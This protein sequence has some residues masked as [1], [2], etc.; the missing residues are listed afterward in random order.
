MCKCDLCKVVYSKDDSI[1]FENKIHNIQ[2]NF[3][4]G[5]ILD[6]EVWDYSF[7]DKCLIRIKEYI[8]LNKDT[9]K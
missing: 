1:F 4:Y 5:S 9:F 6:G 8:E 2:I 3:G 7:C